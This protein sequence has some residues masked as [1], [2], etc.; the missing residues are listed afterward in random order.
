MK[1]WKSIKDCELWEDGSLVCVDG[2]GEEGVGDAHA[3]VCA[4]VL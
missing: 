1:G 3:R 4:C 2:S